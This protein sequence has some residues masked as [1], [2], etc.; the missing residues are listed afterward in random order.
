[1]QNSKGELKTVKLSSA[2][3]FRG[4]E[5]QGK[6]LCQ[7]RLIVSASPRSSPPLTFEFAISSISS[8]TVRRYA[9]RSSISR[10]IWF[11]KRAGPPTLCP[12]SLRSSKITRRLFT[13]FARRISR[14]RCSTLCP[15]TCAV[16]TIRA[17][18]QERAWWMFRMSML[19]SLCAACR[20]AERSGYWTMSLPAC[21]R[22]PFT[23]SDGER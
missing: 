3:G 7:P 19:L 11:K 12:S 10:R 22:A 6:M 1:M 2:S 8:V 20:I 15:C 23:S 4:G 17:Q 14:R 5:T 21:P 16:W 13:N 18:E 9:C